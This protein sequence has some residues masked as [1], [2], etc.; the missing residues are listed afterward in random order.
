MDIEQFK[1]LREVNKLLAVAPEQ[2]TLEWEQD[3]FSRIIDA[4]LFPISREVMVAPDGFPYIPLKTN[5]EGV[6]EEAILIRNIISVAVENGF[7]I[8]INPTGPEMIQVSWVFTYG[9][10]VS[11]QLFGKFDMRTLEE[12][13]NESERKDDGK[14]PGGEQVIISEP[15]ASYLP[16]ASRATIKRF[17]ELGVGIQNPRFGLVTRPNQKS[18]LAF[19]AFPEDINDEGRFRNIIFCLGWF[20]PRHYQVLGVNK[21][22]VIAQQMVAM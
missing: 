20:L 1:V 15:A 4:P 19:S 3:F 18:F 2:Q 22:S 6:T 21:T 14:I 11:F 16:S 5:D 7:G 8:A 13:I 10:L 12:R 17:L 9:D